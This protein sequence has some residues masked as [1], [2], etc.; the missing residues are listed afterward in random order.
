MRKRILS[1]PKKTWRCC[2]ITHQTPV[3]GGWMKW[4]L[5]LKTEPMKRLIYQLLTLLL[6]TAATLG[7]FLAAVLAG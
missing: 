7:L 5:Y 3:I 4:I 2:N 6:A 1:K